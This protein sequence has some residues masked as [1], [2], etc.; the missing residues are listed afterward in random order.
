MKY[1]LIVL[2]YV[3]SLIF[4]DD[5]ISYLPMKKKDIGYEENVCA[6]SY[7]SIIYV[8]Q[9]KEN[10][11]Y[12]K[13][14]EGLGICQDI[15]SK[16][17]T[18]GYNEKCN[19]DFECDDGLNCL[20]T[21][22]PVTTAS[23]VVCGTNYNLLKRKDGWECVHNNYKD[24]CKYYDNSNTANIID[25][26]VSS[27]YFQVCGEIGFKS[28]SLGGTAGTQYTPVKIS[29]NYIGTQKSGTFVENSLACESGFALYF[30][31]DGSS[32]D[33]SSGNYN[34]LYLMC[35]DP[36]DIEYRDDDSCTIKYDNGKLYN[37]DQLNYIAGGRFS[38][39]K[40]DICKGNQYLKIKLELFKKYREVF[41]KDKQE[42]CAKPENY[43]EPYTCND[44]QIRKWY[45]LYNHPE[46]YIEYYDDDLKYNDVIIC[47][48]QQEY[49]SYQIS[50]FLN[51]NYFICLLFL[52]LS[53]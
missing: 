1:C 37:V 43:N 33:P 30:Y 8:K 51:M 29:S 34:I 31:P 21:C 35:V 19:S 46:I 52:L 48:I 5:M 7:S 39:K 20:N 17:T 38:S 28:I 50:R 44:N 2:L 22:T 40:Q 16:I 13:F 15:P 23:A 41:T 24:Y 53:L 27:D 10:G 47:L 49:P 4:S 42:E 11:Q 26:D 18:Y 45:Y 25:E 3:F 36:E 9:C 14:V 6:Y 32:K 12:C